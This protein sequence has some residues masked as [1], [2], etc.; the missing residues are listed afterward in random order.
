MGGKLV[1][2]TS[3]QNS[4]SARLLDSG[5]GTSTATYDM[6]IH[7]PVAKA[8]AI[9]LSTMQ[10]VD[11]TFTT[12]NSSME[13][14][15]TLREKTAVCDPLRS[16]WIFSRRLVLG[17]TDWVQYLKTFKDLPRPSAACELHVYTWEHLRYGKQ[18][19]LDWQW[20]PAVRKGAAEQSLDL[21][22]GENVANYA[23]EA[24]FVDVYKK[25]P[26]SFPLEYGHKILTLM[27][28]LWA[29]ITGELRLGST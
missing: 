19:I 24:G 18:I 3:L 21:D 23:R 9:D 20:F 14:S 11:V 2:I 6:V 28:T 5:C 10:S 4:P 16:T 29:S 26:M 7:Y 1:H 8:Q 17:K 22:C 25:T 27:A 13:T 15:L 12:R